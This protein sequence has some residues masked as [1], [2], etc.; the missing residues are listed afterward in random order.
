MPD[1]YPEQ[2][3]E[4]ERPE[5]QGGGETPGTTATTTRTKDYL[6][7]AIRN[8]ATRGIDHLGR[9]IQT[10]DRDSLGRALVA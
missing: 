4:V 7:R 3:P 8:G 1:E 5:A 10:G 9:D 2:T 6:G